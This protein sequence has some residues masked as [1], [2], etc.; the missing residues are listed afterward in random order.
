MKSSTCATDPMSS[1]PV[2]TFL[3]TRGVTRCHHLYLHSN[4]FY[5]GLNEDGH[6]K[7]AEPN[8][9]HVSFIVFSEMFIF[10]FVLLKGLQIKMIRTNGH[11]TVF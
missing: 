10:G 5:L 6:Q 3:P 8:T 9:K 2:K 11:L 4:I 1:S 7:L